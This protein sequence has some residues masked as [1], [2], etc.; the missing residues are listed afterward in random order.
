[1]EDYTCI[2]DAGVSLKHGKSQLFCLP[3]AMQLALNK[4]T[5]TCGGVI[6]GTAGTD[7]GSATAWQQIQGRLEDHKNGVLNKVPSPPI[8]LRCPTLAPLAARVKINVH[9]IYMP[10][11]S[12]EQVFLEELP[13][14]T[15]ILN[16]YRCGHY[17]DILIC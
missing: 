15:G 14:E 10:R 8:A 12:Y 7:L 1:M 6:K 4:Q 2:T 17:D 11:D 9:T 16:F 5:E 13:S 3:Q